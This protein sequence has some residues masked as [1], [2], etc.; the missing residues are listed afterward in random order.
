MTARKIKIGERWVGAGEPCYIVAEVSANHN[1]SFERALEIIKAAKSAGAD[2]VKLQTYT[3]DTMTMKS[4]LEWFQVPRDSL[5]AGKTLYQ[6]Y[7]EAYTPWDWHAGLQRTA[8]QLGLDFF[9]TPFDATAV[10]FLEGLNVPAYK[11]ASFELIDL[12]LLRVVAKTGKPVIVSTGM[13]SLAEIEEGVTTLRANGAQQIALLKCTS[14]Y[15]ARPS[16][17]N[18][19]TIPDLAAR[20]DTVV[21]LSDHTLGGNTAIT[22]VALGASVIEKH[23]ILARADGGPDSTFSMEPEE[24]AE[25]VKGVREAEQALGEVSYKRSQEETN[26]VC[27]RR[28]LFVVQDVKAGEKFTG[29]NVR[30]IRPGYGLPPRYWG[31]VVGR[32]SARDVPQGTPL[33][34]DLIAGKAEE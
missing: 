12:S 19:R 11:V 27:F 10:A 24:F 34:W 6:L 31:D 2:A 26:S 18:L 5:W 15:P 23:F 4:D 28:S 32:N 7:Q 22:A 20:F 3:P 8:H 33:S 9:S 30:V 17:M 16:E 14:A 13:A 25:M 21:G 1:Q 29:K